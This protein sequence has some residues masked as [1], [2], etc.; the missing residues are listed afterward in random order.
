MF[1]SEKECLQ[2]DMEKSTGIEM[3]NVQDFVSD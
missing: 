3:E 1:Q 2:E